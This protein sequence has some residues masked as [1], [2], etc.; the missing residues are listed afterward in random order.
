MSK[1]DGQKIVIQFDKEIIGDVTGNAGA[2]TI[3]GM[4]RN[5]LG[6]GILALK[7]YT[8]ST[9][10][11]YTVDSVESPDTILLTFNEYNKFND[12]EGDLTVAYNQNLGTLKGLRPVESFSAN[13]LPT[14]LIGTPMNPHTVQANITDVLVGF[15]L[16]TYINIY[17]G[18][19]HSITAG[20]TDVSV[21]FIHIDDINP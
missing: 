3:T 21:T 19:P 15:K 6:T 18:A 13:F 1:R 2:F 8:V 12:S 11:R 10:T 4:Q 17:Q 7:T 16:I 14:Q 9:V 20:I 5:P